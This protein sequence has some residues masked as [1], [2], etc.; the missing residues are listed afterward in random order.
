M[1]RPVARDAPLNLTFDET[2]MH[3]TVR[4][5]SA[6]YPRT[7]GLLFSLAALILAWLARRPSLAGYALVLLLVAVAFGVTGT[8]YL[9]LGPRCSKWDEKF[10]TSFNPRRVTW[11]Q[12]L[13]LTAF[14][15]GLVAI[16]V[17]L[18]RFAR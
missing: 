13:A 2:L 10:V 9:L 6:R 14:G 8:L 12:A 16:A 18:Y 1:S 11:R 3:P 4:R 5:F 7:Y 15:L 17:V